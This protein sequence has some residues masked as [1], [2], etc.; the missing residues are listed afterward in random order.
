[1]FK[2]YAYCLIFLIS[3]KVFSAP[4]YITFEGLVDISLGDPSY[5]GKNMVVTI[6]YDFDLD[7]Y[8]FLADGTKLIAN[9]TTDMDY[10]YAELISSSIGG[11]TFNA[12]GQYGGHSDD[13]YGGSGKGSNNQ[14]IFAFQDSL[15]INPDAKIQNLVVGYEAPSNRWAHYTTNTENI[16]V[17]G[18]TVTYHGLTNP[19]PV[20]AAA[21][22][23][24]SATLGLVS[25][26]RKS[27]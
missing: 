22:L 2:Q 3:G 9:D 17:R 6:K 24:G 4:M 14:S 15:I 1:M 19:V 25:L 7:G 18:F 20:P 13:F 26:K 21:W 11:N 16:Q 12:Y 5:T 23:F 27:K 8:F 10:F